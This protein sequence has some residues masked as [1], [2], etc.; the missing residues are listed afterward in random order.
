MQLTAVR[1]EIV[2]EVIDKGSQLLD[3]VRIRFFMGPVNEGQLLPEIVLRYSF[4]RDQHEF[5]DEPCSHI[6]LVRSYFHRKS[7]LIQ[8]DLCLREIE[9]NTSALFAFCPKDRR[10]LLH[11]PEHRHKS[12]IARRLL[13]IMQS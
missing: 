3:P 11:L 12:F 4:I 8:Y 13:L 2:T 7:R 5:L 9:V 6:S 10:Q 1:M